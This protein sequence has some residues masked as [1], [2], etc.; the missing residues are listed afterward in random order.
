MA[1][2]QLS[3]LLSA[4]INTRRLSTAVAECLS[5]AAQ[6]STPCEIIIID[7]TGDHATS[8]LAD[9]LA[10]IHNSVAVLRFNRRTGYRQALH[11]AWGAASGQS[12]AVLDLNGPA[13]AVSIPRLLS[14]APGHAAVLAYREP[15]SRSLRERTFAVMARR[16]APDLRDP[17]LGLALFRADMRDLLD[18]SVPDSLTHSAAYAT[19]RQRGLS[20]AQ[21]AVPAHS[22]ADSSSRP[23]NALGIG[24]LIAA[25]SLWLLR[26]VI[27]S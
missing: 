10:A 23:S 3:I 17:T 2:V 4:G 13:S 18:A 5:I 21:V 1:Q 19:A 27:R 6:Q 22:E 15:P 16:I 12:I 9:R 25:G 20:V 11:E 26:R 24:M 14:A 8:R 7:N